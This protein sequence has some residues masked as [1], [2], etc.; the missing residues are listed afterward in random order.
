MYNDTMSHNMIIWTHNFFIAVIGPNRL[1]YKML[2]NDCVPSVKKLSHV[3][4]QEVEMAF[5]KSADTP[6]QY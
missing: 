3:G 2:S 6:N 1:D 4:L 5:Q